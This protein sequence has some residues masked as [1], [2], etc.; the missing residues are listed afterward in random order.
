MLHHVAMAKKEIGRPQTAHIAPFG[1]RLQPELKDRIEA[2]SKENGR[3]MNAEIVDRLS[4]SFDA[5]AAIDGSALMIEM[6]RTQQLLQESIKFNKLHEL[7][8]AAR[9]LQDTVRE[10]A[11]RGGEDMKHV[12]EVLLP[13]VFA[14]IDTLQGRDAPDLGKLFMEFARTD[15]KA[16]AI[17]DKAAR[18]VELE[19]EGPGSDGYK[20]APKSISTATRRRTSSS[21]KP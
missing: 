5:G 8:E 3:S 12:Q 13:L 15:P 11:G 21:D 4:R 10:G 7:R 20:A 19:K 1:L 18:L 17:V 14:Q 2:A 16:K 6:R 9:D